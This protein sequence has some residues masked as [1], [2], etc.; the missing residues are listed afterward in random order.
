L[1][2]D[3]DTPARIPADAAGDEA[4]ADATAS[5]DRAKEDDS[6]DGVT[7]EEAGA[8]R[9]P[10]SEADIELD[11]AKP[12]PEPER[13]DAEQPDAAEIEAK[14][15]VPLAAIELPDIALGEA[16]DILGQL[17]S[18]RIEL[19]VEALG[20]AGR[21]PGDRV[22]VSL[23]QTTVAEALAAVL[24]QYNLA[25]DVRQGIIWIRPR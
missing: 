21:S 14:L 1:D 2:A 22:R 8:E 19:D 12:E 13:A 6:Q 18:V 5:D 10:P 24:A 7:Q 16:I 25:Y 3:G 11:P 23:T 17:A 9:L 4:A 15:Q 20:D